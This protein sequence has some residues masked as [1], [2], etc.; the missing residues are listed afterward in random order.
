MP[1]GMNTKLRRLGW[2][3]LLLVAVGCHKEETVSDF[4]Q[5]QAGA[6]ETAIRSNLHL[7]S[8]AAE[9]YYLE[10]GVG[11]A[12]YDDLVGPGKYVVD[13]TPVAGEDYRSLLF[14]QGQPLRVRIGDGRV[15]EYQP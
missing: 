1:M 13:V 11:S 6:E 14:K 7:L 10:K 4:D 12:T 5:A 3:L 9:Q 2:V 8:D 15:I